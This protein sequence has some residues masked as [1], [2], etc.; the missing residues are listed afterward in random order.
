MFHIING[1]PIE[2]L[3]ILKKNGFK[4]KA[5]VDLLEKLPLK[6]ISSVFEKNIL[7]IGNRHK[8]LK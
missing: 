2:N 4:R 3:K 1:K 6:M 5:S 8:K 7:T